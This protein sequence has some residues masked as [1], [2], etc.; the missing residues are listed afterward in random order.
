MGARAGVPSERRGRTSRKWWAK[1]SA[2]PPKLPLPPPLLLPPDPPLSQLPLLSPEV[3]AAAD[4][5]SSG[6]IHGRGESSASATAMSDAAAEWASRAEARGGP[7]RGILFL[8]SPS[9]CG[10]VPGDQDRRRD[11][12]AEA[13]PCC[14]RAPQVHGCGS[15]AQGRRCAA[16]AGAPKRPSP[17]LLP[18][19]RSAPA[20]NS[21]HSSWIRPCSTPGGSAERSAAQK[22]SSAGVDRGQRSHNLAVSRRIR[23]RAKIKPNNLVEPIN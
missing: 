10:L 5:A 19:G 16:E 21:P 6:C 17:V 4:S 15:G 11:W 3:D 18:Q 12:T 7:A 8:S 20:S 9:H 23:R 14:W 13:G 22:T 1:P 2:A